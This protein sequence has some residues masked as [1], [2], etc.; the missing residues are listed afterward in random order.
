MTN[1]MSAKPGKL[2]KTMNFFSP[3]KRGALDRKLI[4]KEDFCRAMPCHR[5]G[6]GSIP[7]QFK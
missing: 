6:L 5:G 4:F 3:A 7:T 2:L 1:H